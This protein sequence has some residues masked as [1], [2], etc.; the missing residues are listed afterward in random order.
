MTTGS[1]WLEP[2][3]G[4]S[5]PA[6]SG[7]AEADV[8]VIGAGIVGVSAALFLAREGADVTV[9]EA[10]RVGGGVTGHTTAKLSSLHG[11]TY[12]TLRSRHGAEAARAYGEANEHG[13]ATVARLVDELEID[14]DLRRRANF[15]YSEDPDQV[16][17]LQAEV[18]AAEAAG[19]RASYAEEVD[20]PFP[21]VGAVRV[22][23]QAEFHP[24]RY[25]LALAEAA[26]AAGAELYERSRAVAL[27]NGSVTLESGATVNADRII[28]AS[29]IP[30]ADRGLWFART[31]PERSYALA[32]RIREDP[33]DAMYLNAESPTRSIRSH[34]LDGGERLLVGGESHRVGAGDE[35]E[36][37]RA[38]ERW[39]RQHWEV[40]EVEY[41]WSAQD[42]MPVDGLPF[43]GRLWPLSDAVL[44]ATG[45]RKWGL[46]MGTTAGEML[47]EL[48]LGRRPQWSDVFRTERLNLVA[49]A[50]DLVSHNA[51]S[52]MHFFAD[53]LTQRAD[54]R[55]LAPG[56]GRVVGSGLGQT[57]LCRDESGRLH[58]LSARCTH[59]GCIVRW[60]TAER[61]WDCPC[62]GSRFGAD[63]EVLQGPAVSP[64]ASK[65]PPEE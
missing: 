6:L 63:G 39:A 2:A 12:A 34:P 48:A 58:A 49:S 50:R 9:V 54:P 19:L 42:N 44:C 65:E 25:L 17:A 40:E 46:A 16:E 57:A 4:P 3:G 28:V 5:W 32:L 60:N 18:E 21:V 64:L 10:L 26:E 51:A 15:T 36:R 27:G 47:A 11:L 7:D 56:E 52:G 13:I 62:H 43:V 37:Y 41:R 38:L 59:L 29:H 24:G 55:G 20:L 53:R 33:P 31:H 22:E 35:A 1:P 14:C 45:F 61:S 30:F 8:A 23:G